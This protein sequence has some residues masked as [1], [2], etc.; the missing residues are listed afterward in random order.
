MRLNRENVPMIEAEWRNFSKIVKY[1]TKEKYLEITVDNGEEILTVHVSF[2]TEGGIR[3]C[4]ADKTGFF[5]PTD[6]LPIAY[7]GLQFRRLTLEAGYERIEIIQEDTSW[8]I[9]F[10]NSSGKHI[11]SL[12]S[13]FFRVGYAGGERKKAMAVFP[14]VPDEKIYGFGERFHSEDMRGSDF[15]LWNLDCFSMFY[16]SYV[17]IPIFHSSAGYSVFFNSL[18]C[19]EV[20]V[21]S[22]D[23][24]HLTMEF[25]GPKWD[26]F[27]YTG[28]PE[29]NIA[30]YVKLTGMPWLPPKWAFRY[31]AGGGNMVWDNYGQGD[32]R[33]ELEKC[34][35]GYVK[36]GTPDIAAVYGEKDPSNNEEGY[37]ILE[38]YNSR[39][40]AWNHPS[41][42]IKDMMK[43]LETDDVSEIPYVMD[44]NDHSK[45]AKRCCID[46]TDPKS[47][48]VIAAYF[49]DYWNW[50]LKGC[51]VDYGEINP[52]ESLFSN[53][54]TG[55]EMHNHF[56]YYYAR[57][58]HNAWKK[59]LGNDYVLFARAGSA[60]YQRWAASFGAD[61]HS[62]F[63][64]LRKALHGMTN[65]VT[66]GQAFW[67][68]DIGGFGGPPTPDLYIR[69]LQF[70]TFSPLMRAHGCGLD[71]NPWTYGK[72]AVDVYRRMYWTR[73]NLLNDIYSYAVKA[74]KT[75]I[76][77]IQP[78][79]VA[80]PNQNIFPKYGAQYMF[81][82]DLMVCP[83]V[84]ENKWEKEVIF[85]KG[86]W[87]DFFTGEP[88]EEKRDQT[89]RAHLEEI[90]V[91]V[92]GGAVIPLTLTDSF[93]VGDS[94][95][96]REKHGTM[97]ITPGNRSTKFRYYS[98]E[99]A[100]ADYKLTCGKQKMT[101][102]CKGVNG[103]SCIM[104]YGKIK[105]AKC[106]RREFTEVHN[107]TAVTKPGIYRLDDNR[108]LI[109]LHRDDWKNV[110][111][112]TE[113][114]GENK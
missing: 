34:M 25:E 53:G 107:G 72:I 85:P 60:G 113:V 89:V 21:G 6:S 68:S 10:Y 47:E 49:R 64:G 37:R 55:D 77:P 15:C 106:G 70:G 29:E 22:I 103:I 88:C 108:T 8:S 67:G 63:E 51:M 91:F 36:I 110:I 97:L 99:E 41:L 50:G 69:W 31:W 23:S 109:K 11:L 75:G 56:A 42:Y 74:N 44:I 86:K 61:Q 35:E 100:F 82:G 38:K 93:T 14:L 9:Y 19:C 84:E 66:S 43:L 3:L 80:F 98:G 17:N 7:S 4:T 94:M 83:V 79:Q 76:M 48:E 102:S 111:L 58:Y 105:S 92:K 13:D 5:E 95:L 33:E 24:E 81:C 87:F 16:R 30:K 96:D 104:V 40:L 90:R 32:Y 26:M 28:T 59:R 57:A 52:L 39:M 62:D 112:Y 45:Q 18:N 20:D 1:E 71:R 78:M 114:G 101:L 65:I 54:M 12:N 46:F 27:V 2:P 73:E